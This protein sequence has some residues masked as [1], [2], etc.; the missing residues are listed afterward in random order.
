MEDAL[1]N[2]LARCIIIT[3]CRVRYYFAGQWTE[4]LAD[5]RRDHRETCELAQAIRP[6]LPALSAIVAEADRVKGVA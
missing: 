3:D 5:G 2:Q 1:R 4:A 6:I